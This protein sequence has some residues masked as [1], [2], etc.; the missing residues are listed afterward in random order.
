MNDILKRN[1]LRGDS[2][3]ENLVNILASSTGSLTNPTRLAN[4]FASNQ[5]PNLTITYKSAICNPYPLYCLLPHSPRPHRSLC[6][7]LRHM[8]C[9]PRI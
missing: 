6:H 5:T 8:L 3:M 9:H 4:T 1:H 2:I 7:L